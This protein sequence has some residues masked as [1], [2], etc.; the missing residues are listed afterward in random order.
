MPCGV[1]PVTFFSLGWILGSVLLCLAF[2]LKVCKRGDMTGFFLWECCKESDEEGVD[3][4][5]CGV[6]WLLEPGG[7]GG[8]GVF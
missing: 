6:G 1:P 2:G 8:G 3:F 7:V 5:W 4:V